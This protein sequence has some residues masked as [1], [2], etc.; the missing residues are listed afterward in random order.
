MKK[1]TLLSS[2][3]ALA[4]I[5]SV[6]AAWTFNEGTVSL[7]QSKTVGVNVNEDV[8]AAGAR[9]SFDVVA[10]DLAITFDQKNDGTLA[11]STEATGTGSITITY[12]HADV[13]N[14]YY[15]YGVTWKIVLPTDWGKDF[16]TVNV[17]PTNLDFVDGGATT[18]TISGAAIAAKISG[19]A[20]TIKSTSNLD[21]FKASVASDITVDI[22]LVV[23]Q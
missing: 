3:A 22:D 11:W 9:G 8:N 23:R 6:Y 12:T 14:P 19:I 10:Q 1:F 5:G 17:N 18:V 15:D 16:V 4:T 20:N 21:D 7:D 13:G 2:L